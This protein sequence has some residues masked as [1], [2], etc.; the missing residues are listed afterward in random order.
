M[1]T[2]ISDPNPPYLADNHE[3]FEGEDEE[4]KGVESEDRGRQTRA[5]RPPG[6]DEASS[7][8]SMRR[9]DTSWDKKW[10]EHMERNSTEDGPRSSVFAK[11]NRKPG[12]LNCST[13]ESRLEAEKQERLASMPPRSPSVGNKRRDRDDLSPN[14]KPRFP[15]HGASAMDYSPSRTATPPYPTV[16]DDT[17]LAD[18]VADSPLPPPPESI[19]AVNGHQ[20]KEPAEAM[21]INDVKQQM[22]LDKQS[23]Q[24]E[25]ACQTTIASINQTVD[26]ASN[27]G[28]GEENVDWK[29][30][31][32]IIAI[33]CATIA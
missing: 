31:V 9:R 30:K 18:V 24:P 15:H 33:F 21:V 26:P 4:E 22:P 32:G 3:R 23:Q 29:I 28:A 1:A 11:S 8:F 10:Q 14:L 5:S 16:P 27:S 12:K 19:P 17:P 13:W 2:T 7:N 25:E 6:R 20:E